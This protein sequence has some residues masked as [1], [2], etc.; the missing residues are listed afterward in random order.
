MKSFLAICG[1]AVIVFLGGAM[2]EEWDVFAGPWFA[3]KPAASLMSDDDRRKASNAVYLYLKLTSHLAGTGGDQR[4][5]DRI[6]ASDTL[7]GETL[8]GIKTSPGTR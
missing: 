4:F 3:K 2:I 1:V 7:V 5:A 8:A 6:P